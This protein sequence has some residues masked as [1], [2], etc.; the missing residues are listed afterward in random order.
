MK[1]RFALCLAMFLMFNCV[2]MPKSAAVS[3]SAS[4]A[5][6]IDASSGEVLYEKNADQKMLIASITKIMTGLVALWYGELSDTVT[7][8]KRA[9]STIGS[10]MY[11][12]AGEK[13]TLEA[14]LY[15]LLL[16]SGND[17]GVAIAEHVGGGNEAVFIQRMNETA[18][19]LGMTNSSFANPHG[20]DDKNHYSTARD[21]AKLASVAM[22][23][24][25]FRRIVS[26]KTI[27][28]YGRTLTN[29]NKLLG[30]LDGC[31][32]VKNGYTKAAGR[33]LVTCVERNGRRLIAVTLKDG[34][35]YNDHK[36]LYEYGF[37]LSPASCICAGG[38]YLGEVPVSGAAKEYFPLMAGG[39]L[40]YHVS[41][42]DPVAMR[43]ELYGELS[44]PI[45]A[46][47]PVGV[48]VYSLY[49]TEI[50]R[51][52]ALMG[53]EVTEEIYGPEDVA[54][55]NLYGPEEIPSGVAW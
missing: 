31:V 20:L 21:M 55:W 44:A 41:E 5:I 26:T 29:H 28:V 22:Q 48:A 34:N 47:T 14:L 13:L 52:P 38:A 24:P 6:L 2:T 37:S 39:E 17:A 7:V 45:A 49:G 3:V 1:K 30:V 36:A 32:G 51:V 53:E 19:A 23:H 12:K 35:D 42:Y 16:S 43:I 27:T 4:S 46:G 8:S 10:S 54:I 11:L 18:R 9:A 33:T 50:G 25:V 15:G 40:Y